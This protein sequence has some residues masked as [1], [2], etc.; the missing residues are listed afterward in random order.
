LRTNSTQCDYRFKTKTNF[1]WA[2]LVLNHRKLL[3]RLSTG[4]LNHNIVVTEAAIHKQL[5]PSTAIEKQTSD[6]GALIL[7]LAARA[8]HALEEPTCHA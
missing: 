5:P 6:L 1:S 4:D 3:P 8:I 7:A 2:S